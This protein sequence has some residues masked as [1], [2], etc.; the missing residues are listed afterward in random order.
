MDI[1]NNSLEKDRVR[2]SWVKTLEKLLRNKKRIRVL[3][4]AGYSTDV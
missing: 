2:N 1:K 3:E 4:M